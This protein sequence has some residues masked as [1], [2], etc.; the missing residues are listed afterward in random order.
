M[1]RQIVCTQC[2]YQGH[3]RTVTRG[4]FGVE[5]LLWLFFIVP[6]LIYSVWR[7]TTRYPGCPRCQS[8]AVIP[9][10]SPRASEYV[11]T[12]A[13]GGNRKCPECAE[14]IK[15]EAKKCRFCGAQTHF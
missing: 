10:D 5:L 4:S 9:H 13:S 8:D 7:L 2:G 1:P 15:A 3:A 11:G 14:T 12:G 6:G